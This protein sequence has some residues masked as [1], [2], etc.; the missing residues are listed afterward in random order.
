MIQQARWKYP[1]CQT[2]VSRCVTDRENHAIKTTIGRLAVEANRFV[3]E[4]PVMAG[5]LPTAHITRLSGRFG[6]H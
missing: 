2:V 3:I 6:M 1:C 4:S 5:T